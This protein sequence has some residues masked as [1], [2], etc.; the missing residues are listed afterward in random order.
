M[1]K[2][3]IS[4]AL[5][6]VL[7][8][9]GCAGATTE[10]KAFQGVREGIVD[11]KGVAKIVVDG[12]DIWEDGEP[13]RK[14]KVLGFIDDTRGTNWIHTTLHRGDIV[15]KAREAGGDAVIKLNAQSQLEG[16]YSAGGASANV[17]GVYVRTSHYGSPENNVSKY[18]VVKYVK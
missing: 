5:A 16:F 6:I 10:Y 3:T 11:G 12:M 8:L 15:K 7:S 2:T 9:A 4:T 18:A 1:K 13:P 14:F 17:Y